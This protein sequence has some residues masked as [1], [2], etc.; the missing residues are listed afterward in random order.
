[1]VCVEGGQPAKPRPSWQAGRL[2][3]PPVGYEGEELGHRAQDREPAVPDRLSSVARMLSRFS[4]LP[5]GGA[6]TMG[7]PSTGARPSNKESDLTKPGRVVLLRNKSV[8]LVRLCHSS[9]RRVSR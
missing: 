8:M 6:S 9:R 1:M 3:G 2:A 7:V 5:P 4:T